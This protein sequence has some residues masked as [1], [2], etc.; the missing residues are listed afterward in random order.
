MYTKDEVAILKNENSIIQVYCFK[1]KNQIDINNCNRCEL[2][3]HKC[4][5]LYKRAYKCFEPGET[6]G[7]YELYCLQELIKEVRKTL[8]ISTKDVLKFL[9]M[10]K[11]I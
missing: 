10:A 2:Y 9:L 1:N 5:N 11:K 7:E 6:L 8:M 3:F 4:R